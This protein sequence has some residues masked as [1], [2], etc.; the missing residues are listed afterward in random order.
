[1]IAAAPAAA[2]T[3][4]AMLL[5]GSIND[6]SLFR[7]VTAEQARVAVRNVRRDAMEHLKKLEKEHAISQ[8]EHKRLDTEVQKLTDETNRSW[9]LETL[10]RNIGATSHLL[11]WA[12]TDSLADA[13]GGVKSFYRASFDVATPAAPA[14]PAADSTE[15]KGEAKLTL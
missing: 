15:T 5:P 1:M 14:E 4:V 13:M 7:S 6:Q 2:Q 8:D 9:G 12:D 3:K 11:T 10:A